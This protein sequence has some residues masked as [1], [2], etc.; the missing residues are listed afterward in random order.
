VLPPGEGK[1][2]LSGIVSVEEKLDGA[3]VGISLDSNAALRVQNRGQYLIKPY[4]GQFS[5]LFGWLEQHRIGLETVLSHDLILFGEWCA[6]VHSVKYTRLSDWFLLF[7]VY[8]RTE[9]K[10]WSCS[11][12]DELAYRAGID[13]VPHLVREKVSLSG[14]EALLQ[15][16][17]SSFCDGPME[18]LVIRQ[19]SE[20]WNEAR[21]KL[22]RA[23][24]TQS[25]G[26]HWR[27]RK[28]AWNL[29]S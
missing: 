24:F 25:I 1:E 23:D 7:D 12:R 26:Q 13:V 9:G 28:L 2:L 17:S 11:R 6:A 18:G 29:T 22:V 16:S 27:S 19:D 14:L 8:D 15:K 5:R 20:K 4:S 21:A 10:F 3:N